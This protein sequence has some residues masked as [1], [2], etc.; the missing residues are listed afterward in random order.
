MHQIV[1]LARTLEPWWWSHRELGRGVEGFRREKLHH[2]GVPHVIS[3]RFYPGVGAGGGGGVSGF[4]AK[5]YLNGPW[6]FF[7][8]L[9]FQLIF[10]IKLIEIKTESVAKGNIEFAQIKCFLQKLI[11]PKKPYKN[12]TR[13]QIPFSSILYH[14]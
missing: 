11:L 14:F 12:T 5:K 13:Q 7:L 10:E 4:L 2:P 8:I 3:Y 1:P 6:V 9:I